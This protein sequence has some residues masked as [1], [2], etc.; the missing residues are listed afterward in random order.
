MNN[1]ITCDMHKRGSKCRVENCRLQWLSLTPPPI[2]LL[3]LKLL[4]TSTIMNV[5]S[6]KSTLYIY[7][8]MHIYILILT[9]GKTFYFTPHM[10]EKITFVHELNCLLQRA[11]ALFSCALF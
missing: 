10:T 5:I 2:K 3:E 8:Y 6:T 7:I 4:C 11:R 9:L 1:K